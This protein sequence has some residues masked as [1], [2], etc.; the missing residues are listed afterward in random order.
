MFDM[1][2]VLRTLR[3]VSCMIL[4]FLLGL[5]VSVKHAPYGVV[6]S[7]VGLRHFH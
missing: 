5:S 7:C 3:K 1:R 4:L 2:Q 6:L